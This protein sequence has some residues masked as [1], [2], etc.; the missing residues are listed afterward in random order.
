M[1]I[2]SISHNYNAKPQ[3]NVSVSLQVMA[4]S[5]QVSDTIIYPIIC[6]ETN[7]PY[8]KEICSKVKLLC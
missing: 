6:T 8:W 5:K 7:E 3:S 1:I 4:L 2:V